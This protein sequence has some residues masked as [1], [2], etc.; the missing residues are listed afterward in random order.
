[1]TGARSPGIQTSVA[2][3]S[4]RLA[5]ITPT[6]VHRVPAIVSDVAPRSRVAPSRVRQNDSLTT[7]TGAAPARFSSGA[8]ARPDIG[9]TP[10]TVK[11]SRETNRTLALIGSP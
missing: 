9:V 2:P 10:R 6:T 5:G 8:I 1:M 7:T 4:R 3:N 11:N